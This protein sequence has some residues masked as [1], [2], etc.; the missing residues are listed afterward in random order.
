MIVS[1][2]VECQD[3]LSVLAISSVATAGHEDTLRIIAICCLYFVE[4]S[5]LFINAIA[6]R[7]MGGRAAGFAFFFLLLVIIIGAQKFNIE[8]EVLPIVALMVIIYTGRFC[9]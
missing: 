9:K 2:I 3:F 1:N 4:L 7:L 5:V 8:I 6:P